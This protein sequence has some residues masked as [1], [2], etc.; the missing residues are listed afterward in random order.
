MEFTEGLSKQ[1]KIAVIMRNIDLNAAEKQSQVALILSDGEVV[2]VVENTE[3]SH[4]SST[5]K[6]CGNCFFECCQKYDNCHRY[7]WDVVINDFRNLTLSI[8]V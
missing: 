7:V 6:K 3:C 5:E 8:S 1:Q 2:R 4:Y